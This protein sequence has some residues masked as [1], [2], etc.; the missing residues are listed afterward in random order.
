MD[1]LLLP[2]NSQKSGN[3]L[4]DVEKSLAPDF[5]TTYR[6]EYE[7]WKRGTPEIDLR[8][9]IQSI[10]KIT[11]LERPYLVFAK[12]AGTMLSLQAMHEQVITPNGCLLC[13]IP[14]VM[15]RDHNL[16]LPTWLQS[17][18]VPIIIIQNEHDPYGSY[19]EVREYILA[20]GSHNVTVIS[21]PGDSHD[22]L[23]FEFLRQT[24]ETLR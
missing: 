7:H 9:E 12:S 4:Q 2:G 5:H 3:W 22:Y 11:E 16:P 18:T 6:H 10:S 17:T 1:L 19:E 20:S 21:H 24:L 14:L 15:V 23:D 8:F 13:G